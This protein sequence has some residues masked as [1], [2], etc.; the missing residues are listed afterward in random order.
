MTARA[1]G[2]EPIVRLRK[3]LELER[4]Q[5]SRN[6][7]VMGG[8]DRFLRTL[9]EGKGLPDGSPASGAIGSLP[10]GG[11]EA[12]TQVERK[13]WLNE[14]LA[15]AS[16]RPAPPQGKKPAAPPRAKQPEHPP[17]VGAPLTVLKGVKAGLAGRFDTIGV[18]TVRDLL[19][20]FPRRHND[21][22]NLRPIAELTAG[23]DET[24]WISRVCSQTIRSSPADVSPFSALSFLT[25]HHPSVDG[26]RLQREVAWVVDDHDRATGPH[27]IP[28]GQF[29]FRR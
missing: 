4:K 11:Y 10:A 3:V 7:A 27:S 29:L 2:D 12:L 13:R 6:T 15:A 28:D 23:A 19:Y 18:R 16:G 25:P 17:G 22:A 9:V 5:G 24:I 1:R 20:L 21:F 8:L 14:A 26:M